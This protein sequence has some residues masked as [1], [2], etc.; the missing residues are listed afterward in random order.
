MSIRVPPVAQVLL[1]GLLGWGLSTL[2][3]SPQISGQWLL[4]PAVLLSGGGLVLL[5]FAVDAFVRAK[6]TVNPLDPESAE[7]LVT[8]GLFR[9][10]RNPMYLGM[11]LV[12]T[13]GVIWLGAWSAM[14]APILFIWVI[15]EI[16]I[17]P[18]E[19]V[20]QQ[21]FGDQFSDYRR[22]TRRWF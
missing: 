13:G 22:Q 11:L 20:L 16:Q 4:F 3:P 10:S 6:T 8:S 21:K 14:L 19:R 7:E 2:F 17:K 1:C 12:L 9:F 15:T 18:E 5:T